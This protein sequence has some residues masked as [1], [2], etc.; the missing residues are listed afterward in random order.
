MT[1]T[2]K[3]TVSLVQPLAMPTTEYVV[4]EVGDTVMLLLRLPLDQT[5]ILAPCTVSVVLSLRSMVLLPVMVTT[6]MGLMV[7]IRVSICVQP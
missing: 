6:G 1:L 4:V 3:L 7:R 5:Y 2:V